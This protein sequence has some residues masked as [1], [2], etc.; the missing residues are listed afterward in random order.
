MASPELQAPDVAFLCLAHTC[1]WDV[2]QHQLGDKLSPSALF[3]L[4]QRTHPVLPLPASWHAVE[5]IDSPP[6]KDLNDPETDLS[7]LIRGIAHILPL[8]LQR[9]VGSYL[10]RHI[11][12]SLLRAP[13]LARSYIQPEPGR[14]SPYL[15]NIEIPSP[16]KILHVSNTLILGH[17]YLSGI[18]FNQPDARDCITIDAQTVTALHFAI[19]TYGLRALRVVFDYAS[20]SPWV[21]SQDSECWYG[22]LATHNFDLRLLRLLIAGTETL[23]LWNSSIPL[24]PD[25]TTHVM[26]T[27]TQWPARLLQHD[28]SCRLLSYVPLFDGANYASGLTVYCSW[29]SLDGFIVEGLSE[30]VVVGPCKG[31]PVFLPLRPGERISSAWFR[32]TDPNEDPIPILRKGGPQLLVMSQLTT[33]LGRSQ[34]FGRF[35]L[36]ED[37]STAGRWAEIGNQPGSFITG[38]CLDELAPEGHGWQ[39]F[40]TTTMKAAKCPGLSRTRAHYYLPSE[41]PWPLP[42]WV[43][44]QSGHMLLLSIASFQDVQGLC[45][46]RVGPRCTGLQVLHSDNK[47]EVL[48]QWYPDESSSKSVIYH[49]S[50]GPLARVAFWFEKSQKP[51]SKD[52]YVCRISTEIGAPSPPPLECP[53]YDVN[54]HEVSVTCTWWSTLGSDIICPWIGTVVELDDSSSVHPTAVVS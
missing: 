48:G 7:R 40:G 28:P 27:P 35:K 11:V 9:M 45:V 17:M 18:Q 14:S 52:V 49:R 5:A 26:C 2:A 54:F 4:A 13:Q 42:M 36:L 39:Y 33:N 29:T 30:K 43:S 16:V 32:F 51:Q 3:A 53:F 6:V 25:H 46:C 31:R 44:P 8:E 23:A 1:C 21:G 41:A 38:L 37:T 24:D 22:K 19:G 20:L 12:A 10:G 34:H 50:E 47:I 15:D